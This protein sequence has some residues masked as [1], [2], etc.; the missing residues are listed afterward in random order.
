VVLDT[1]TNQPRV[2]SLT[3][4]RPGLTAEVDA[5]A[6]P[7]DDAAYLS[8]VGICPRAKLRLC[9]AGHPFVVELCDD[10]GPGCRIAIARDLARHITVRVGG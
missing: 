4:L 1:A 5:A 9:R 6:L 3:Q 8:A 2:V 10:C 7:P